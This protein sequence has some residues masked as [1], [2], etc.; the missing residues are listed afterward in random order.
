M[1]HS[2]QL[3]KRLHQIAQYIPKGCP[4]ADIGSD[5]A[6]LPTFLVQEGISPFVI[7]GEVNRGPW[8]SAKKQIE[9]SGLSAYVDVRLGDG[10][11]VVSPEEV[12]AIVIAGMGG[13]LMTEILEGGKGKLDAV[14]RLI[15]QPNVGEELVRRW[16]YHHHWQLVDESILEE[17][18]RIYE[19]VVAEKGDREAPYL[20]QPWDKE[21]LFHIGPFLW[22]RQPLLLRIKWE[23][24][25]RKMERVV[26]QL[27]RSHSIE[28]QEKKEDFSQRILSIQEVL[29]CLPTDKPL[30]NT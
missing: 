7:A 20:N 9:Q 16:L 13:P 22:K 2:I 18:G 21:V 5:H 3:S 26:K 17:G 8:K 29:S 23:E 24:E 11:S 30:S 28:A 25:L 1:N 10:L 14:K 15:L 4:V 6:Y 12:D 27:E 19:I